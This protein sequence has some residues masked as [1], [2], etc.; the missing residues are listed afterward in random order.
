MNTPV[1]QPP[2]ASLPLPHAVP[3]VPP[4][5]PHSSV[6]LADVVHVSTQAPSHFTSHEA[7]SE[8]V[9]VLPSPSSNLQSADAEQDAVE[10]APPLSWHLL[11]E[12]HASVLP[13]P[14]SAL[15][16]DESSHV[17]VTAPVPVALHF[18]EELHASEHGAP[19]QSVLQSVPA[20]HVQPFGVVQV[21][22]V[23]VQVAVDELPDPQAIARALANDATKTKRVKRSMEPPSG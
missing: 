10:L 16:C 18:D 7:L 1:Q 14:P 4:S 11:D 19:P 2:H 17:S 5:G 15:H 22:P 20:T 13:S 23:P 6:Q 12:L 9:A 8:Q 3:A 21:H